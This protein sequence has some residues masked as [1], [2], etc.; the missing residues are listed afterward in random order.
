M[1]NKAKAIFLYLLVIVCMILAAPFV[2]ANYQYG[3]EVPER[4]I[5]IDKKIK[6]VNKGGEWVDN[7]F[8]EE[9]TYVASEKVDFRVVVKNSGEEDLNNI[10]VIDYLPGE[11]YFVSGP[12]EYKADG[13]QAEWT[14]DHL[15]S[16]EEKEFYLEARVVESEKLVS[17]DPFCMLNRVRAEAETGESDEDTAQLCVETR[18]LGVELPPT[19]INL[20]LPGFLA[21]S[22][23]TLGLF[24]K[25]KLK[26]G[27]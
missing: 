20:V 22:I 9:F 7:L 4:Q 6:A 11:V 19:G 25:K 1:N 15:N 8:A 26:R 17:R 12:G 10:K 27:V 13:H 5:I 24:L 23:S 2:W 14:I 16:G 18:I 21:V 3:G